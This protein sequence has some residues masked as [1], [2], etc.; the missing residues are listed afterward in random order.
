MEV[1]VA[2][3]AEDQGLALPR[4]HDYCPSRRR[5]SVFLEVGKFP[6]MVGIGPL[7]GATEFALRLLVLLAMG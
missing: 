5:P 4:G 2:G 3:M 1:T 6:N 7:G